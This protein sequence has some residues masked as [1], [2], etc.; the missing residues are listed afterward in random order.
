MGEAL[1]NLKEYLY[2]LPNGRVEDVHKVES[3][4]CRA[5]EES[6]YTGYK[7]LKSYKILERLE[8][9]EWDPP[10][11]C[12]TIERHGAMKYGSSRAELQDWV[13]D[14]SNGSA[15]YTATRYRQ[16]Y[17]KSPPLKT[18]PLAEKIGKLIIEHSNDKGLKWNDGKTKVRILIG[19]VIQDDTAKQ[20]VTA[21]RKRFRKDLTEF[22]KKYGWQ[23]IRPN[24]YSV[25]DKL[26]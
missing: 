6:D 12:F 16:K 20:T 26:R 21:R 4:I 17:R 8:N 2:T 10:Y 5:W 19:E 18:K 24:N 11:L 23:E 3:L 9:L 15:S 14:V 13:F 22:L 25:V 7:G 1:R